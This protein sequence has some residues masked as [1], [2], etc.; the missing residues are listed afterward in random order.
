MLDIQLV[1]LA[2]TQ[3][4]IRRQGASDF[5][6]SEVAHAARARA[7]VECRAEEMV[8]TATK[9]SVRLFADGEVA[10]V[11]SAEPAVTTAVVVGSHVKRLGLGP[12]VDAWYFDA[13]RQRRVFG[14]FE[15]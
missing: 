9:E 1:D 2:Q 12:D 5:A 8:V 4:W 14:H 3:L 13:Q 11:R 6:H 15:L 10:D 7:P